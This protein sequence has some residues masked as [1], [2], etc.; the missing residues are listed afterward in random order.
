MSD[1]TI[2]I[3]VLWIFLFIYSLLGSVDFGAGFW[4][5]IF[6]RRS[7]DGDTKA[8]GLANRF[9]SPSWKI[10]NT[11]LVLFVV[12]LVG[13]FPRA[14]FSL[15][16]LLLVPVCLVLILLTLRSAFMVFSYS[17]HSYDRALRIISGITGLLIPGLLVAVLA[18]TLGGIVTEAPDGTLALNYG[19][20]LTS[21]TLYAHLAFGY[22]TELFFSALFLADYAREARDMTTYRTYR[23]LAVIFGP[24]SLIAAV[25]VTFTMLPEASWIIARFRDQWLWFLLSAAA[26]GIG[27]GCLFIKR[28]GGFIGS[29]RLAVIFVAVQY[30]LASL[31]YGRA[32]LP[33]IIYPQLTLEA[34]FTNPAIFRSL[35]IG[36][37]VSTILLIPVFI[38]FWRLFLKDR[39]YLEQE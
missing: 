24:L 34:G 21:P 39:R 16:S 3:T 29:T 19:K 13:F 17:V 36:Y 33:Y 32:H 14:T 6:G 23:R 7:A 18:V 26:F 10:T 15:A 37:I 4:A 1:A 25:G 20:L 12:A 30:A 38:L 11:F 28:R 2:A 9:L 31:A 5:M 22:A 35:L 27:Y 8:A